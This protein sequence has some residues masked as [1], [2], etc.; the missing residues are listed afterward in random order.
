MKIDKSITVKETVIKAFGMI[1]EDQEFSGLE[2]KKMC[3][4]LNPDFKNK[5]EDTFM[6]LLR[7]Y[8]RNEF[9]CIDRHNSKYKKIAQM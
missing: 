2:F 5:F 9:I 4:R 7:M 6:R 8:K 3:V 1:Q